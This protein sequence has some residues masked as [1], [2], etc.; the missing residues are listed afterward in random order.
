MSSECYPISTLFPT[1]KLFRDF[2]GDGRGGGAVARPRVVSVPS[3]LPGRGC[4]TRS[5]WCLGQTSIGPRSPMRSSGRAAASAPGPKPWPIS[6]KLRAGARAVVTGQQVGLLGGP[7]LTLLKAATAVARAK[8]ATAATGIEHVPMFW[9]AT[10]DH[11]LEEVDQVS[12]LSKTSVETLRLARA[13]RPRVRAG[14]RRRAWG[15]R[16]ARCWT[17]PANCWAMRRSAT[18]C[19]SVMT[20][21]A[22]QDPPPPSPAALRA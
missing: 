21:R 5:R 18:C 14:R 10:E 11:D 19:A 7:L 22:R 9:L 2:L 13:C 4:G 15:R 3:R 16:W 12:L 20:P 6:Q 8:Q 17:R 1:T